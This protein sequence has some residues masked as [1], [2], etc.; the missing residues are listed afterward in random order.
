MEEY[1]PGTKHVIQGYRQSHCVDRAYETPGA[2]RGGGDSHR[3]AIRGC[4]TQQGMVFASLSLEQGLQISI[5]VWNR[6]SFFSCDSGTWS[7]Y[8]FSARITL[9]M[10]VVAVPAPVPL[11]VYSNMPFPNQRSTASCVLQS[12]T[13]Y[14]FSPFCLEQGSTIVPL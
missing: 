12:G 14:L 5:S 11:H 3:C 7:G 2:G 9:Q 13:G 1:Q 4:A 6:V 10:N 8:F